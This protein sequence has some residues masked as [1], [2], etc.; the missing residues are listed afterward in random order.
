MKT[1]D[2]RSVTIT[3]ENGVRFRLTGSGAKAWKLAVDELCSTIP[4]GK[5]PEL[6]W[7]VILPKN[8]VH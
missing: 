6:P 5:F 3:L 1:P 2:I 8:A 4:S 7:S